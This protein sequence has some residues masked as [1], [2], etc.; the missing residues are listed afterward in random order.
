M[1]IAEA[2]IAALGEQHALA[3]LGEIGDQ[4]LVVFLEDLRA[5]RHLAARHPRRRAPVRLL[6]HA[7]AAASSP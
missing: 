3:R 6:A 2:A 4:R 7:V 5:G 1:R